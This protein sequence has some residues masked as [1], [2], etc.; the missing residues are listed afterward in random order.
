[1]NH[2]NPAILNL[3][4]SKTGKAKN[5]IRK[6][7]SLIRRKYPKCTINAAAH[8]YAIENNFSLRQKLDKE[9]KSS[10]PN[11]EI[12]NVPIVKVKGR[13]VAKKIIRFINY[14][15]TNY[16]ISGHINEVNKTYTNGCY[17]ATFILIRK[18]VENL[19]IDILR[20]KF[21]EKRERKNKELY[22][23]IPQQRLHDFSIVLENLYK[24]RIEFGIEGK[25]VIERFFQLVKILKKD[26]NDKTHSW[27]HLVE[28]K[29]EFD[30]IN[31]TQIF[32]LIIKLESIIG[33]RQH[34]EGAAHANKNPAN[35]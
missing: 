31:V 7:I 4:I 1:M 33:L 6:N 18:I 35:P 15:S 34:N 9:D 10:L 27:F 30:D 19:I 20:Y 14:E 11:L 5:T 28:S 16:F 22:Y 17:T 3:I 21:P 13:K 29:T 24:K 26:A 32:Q 25:G 2:L 23:N 12:E 8:I